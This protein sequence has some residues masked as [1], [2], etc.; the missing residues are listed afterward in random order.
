MNEKSR[1]RELSASYKQ[2]HPEAGVY[3]IVNAR[4][5]KV[6]LGSAA[7]LASMRNKL[8]FARSTNTPSAL[9]RKLRDDVRAFGIEAF[10]FEVLESF[11]PSPELTT[12][13]I[14]EELAVLEALWRERLDPALLY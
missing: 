8:E 12:T 3:R 9:D 7:N 4:N 5:G 10:S 1:R 13:K 11:A 2:N 14:R 6:L